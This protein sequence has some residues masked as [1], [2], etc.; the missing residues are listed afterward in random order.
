MSRQYQQE[1][2]T[3]ALH[4]YLAIAE[5]HTPVEYPLDGRSVAK[6]L[7]VNLTTLYMYRLQEPIRA[8]ANHQ[9]ENAKVA[10]KRPSLNSPK[11]RL[12]KLGGELKLAEERNKH[13]VARLVLVEA[14][15]MRLGIDSGELYLP[16]LKPVRTVS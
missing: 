15:A 13:L 5:K 9:R 16:V 7:R 4:T 3:T 6:A 8:A 11:E 12:Q 10:G 1:E 14:N 2:L